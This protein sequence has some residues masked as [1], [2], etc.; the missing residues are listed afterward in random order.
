MKRI[1]SI[2]AAIALLV[3]FMVP[4]LADDP[5]PTYAINVA[6]A[7]NGETYAAYKIFDVTYDGQGAYTYTYTSSTY[8]KTTA[9]DL[10]KLITE[11]VANYFV[12]LTAVPGV[13]NTYLVTEGTAMAADNTDEENPIPAATV[14]EG[15]S[16]DTASKFA[17]KLQELYKAGTWFTDAFK[18]VARKAV[19]TASDPAVDTEAVID[20]GAITLPLQDD[21]YYFVTTTQ[22]SFVSVDTA[23]KTAYVKDKT[24]QPA[25]KKEITNFDSNGYNYNDEVDYKVTVTAKNGAVNYK[26]VDKTPKGLTLTSTA[27]TVALK[28]GTTD[29]VKDQ[30]Y[31]IAITTATGDDAATYGSIITIQFTK[32]YLDTIAEDTNITIDYKGVVN[33]DALT[34]DDANQ[35][36]VYLSWGADDDTIY[37]TAA[38]ETADIVVTKTNADG[39]TNLNGVK[40][41][42]YTSATGGD[43]LSFVSKNGTYYCVN[44]PSTVPTGETAV[45]ELVTA[46][47]GSV[48]GQLHIDTLEEGDY[49]F[50]ETYTLDGYNLP[51]ER[52]RMTVAKDSTSKSILAGGSYTQTITNTQGTELPETGGIGTII[53][54]TLGSIAVLAAGI[55]LISNKRIS[56]E[57]L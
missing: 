53:F 38:F 11:L 6:N 40:F 12:V 9:S 57:E 42:V 55:F 17:K 32:D 51:T 49:W 5:V 21:G 50:E 4:V 44:N 52:I 25:I 36:I 19:T 37:D 47:I 34:G 56:K 43:P 28:A 41:K 13:A 3:T 39:S 20:G 30:D 16:A 27:A 1:L 2:V 29:L 35:N 46:T 23:D 54:V 24:Q 8:G 22:G 31:T 7:R 15:V 48:A 18:S 10:D 45:I 33:A 26:V 14:A